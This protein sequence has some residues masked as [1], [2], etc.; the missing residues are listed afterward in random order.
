MPTEVPTRMPTP[1][2]AL[3]PPPAPPLPKPPLAGAAPALS[4]ELQSFITH[5]Q[6]EKRLAA[7]TLAMYSEALLRLQ[8]SAAVD[9]V[10]LRAATPLHIRAW[11]GQLRKR[12]LA[13]RS[14]AIALAAWRDRKS[15]V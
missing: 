4:P 7:R 8:A 11:V 6:V 5:L 1:T 13:P 15:V 3:S 2:P 9:G 14:I 12:G 10:A